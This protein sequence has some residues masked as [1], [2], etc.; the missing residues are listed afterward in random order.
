MLEIPEARVVADQLAGAAGGRRVATV[1]A[2][3][4]PHR[5]AFFSGDPRAYDG[6]LRGKDVVGTEA[7]GGFVEL[8][9]GDTSLLFSDGANLRFHE[10]E[11]VLPAKHQLLV[12]FDD[13]SA[14]TATV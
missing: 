12:T 11:A 5:F 10:P 6:M 1:V 2:G 9:V 3:Q 8:H 4:S 14:L 7:F 13:G